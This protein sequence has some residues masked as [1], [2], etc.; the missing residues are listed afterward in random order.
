[1]KLRAAMAL[2]SMVDHPTPDRIIPGPF[3][4]GVADAVAHA[5]KSAAAAFV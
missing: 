4:S 5:V 2:A 1:M 3:E